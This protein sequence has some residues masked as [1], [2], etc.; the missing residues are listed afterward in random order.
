MGKSVIL[1]SFL[2]IALLLVGC[3]VAPES[4]AFWLA[5]KSQDYT[6]IRLVLLISLGLLLVTNPP[7]NKVLRTVIGAVA[8]V[9]GLWALG[10]T[11]QNEMQILDSMSILAASVSAGIAVLE[12]VPDTEEIGEKLATAKAK[13]STNHTQTA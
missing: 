9:T 7:R 12:Y 11:Y 13:I 1:L 8:S 5:T 6:I 2:G 3:L 10:Q 4:A